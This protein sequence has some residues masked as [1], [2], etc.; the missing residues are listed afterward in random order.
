MAT[1]WNAGR[2]WNA[3]SLPGDW[4]YFVS[5]AAS[6]RSHLVEHGTIPQWNFQFCGGTPEL[7][8]PQ[9]WAYA[10]PS[11]FAY[12]LPPVIALLALWAAMTAL[13]AFSLWAWLR[14]S[15]Y[16]RPAA[17][18][19]VAT[20][21]FSGFF[22]AQFNQGHATFA[23]FHLIPPLLLTAD[24]F[25][26]A[27]ESA[28]ASAKA[29]AVFFVLTGLLLFSGGLPHALFYAYPALPLFLLVRSLSR[30]PK[31][32]ALAELAA[33][34]AASIGLAA[35]KLWPVI[36]WEMRHPRL[37]VQIETTPLTSILVS[38]GTAR[39][40]FFPREIFFPGQTWGS[41]EHDA[42]IGPAALLAAMIA[43]ALIFRRG[44]GRRAVTAQA[45]A[46]FAGVGL[47]L[48][49]GNGHPLSPAR[50][51]G[52]LP[53]LR[54][55]RVFARYQF[56]VV[57]GASI[58]T[59]HGLDFLLES[60]AVKRATRPAALL[61]WGLSALIAAPVLR[62]A[63]FLIRDIPILDDAEL[64]RSYELDPHDGT[65]KAAWQTA[66]AATEFLSHQSFLLRR[67]ASV[68]NCYEPL[69]GLIRDVPKDLLDRNA[70]GG[71]P[72]VPLSQPTTESVARFARSIA[73]R[74]GS[75]RRPD[76][77]VV[78]NYPPLRG[79]SISVPAD[80]TLSSPPQDP[81]DGD[82]KNKMIR[83]VVRFDRLPGETL[84][85]R[86]DRDWGAT[87]GAAVSAIALL[88][89]AAALRRRRVF[90]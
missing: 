27:R 2:S 87:A 42:Y 86:A 74:F 32:K 85:V 52:F 75:A 81:E 5:H 26:D 83:Q 22:A 14:R 71:P 89:A 64:D 13:G 61:A 84:R 56:L 59:A 78:L 58:L 24:S 39:R 68:I 40:S 49:L 48:A 38:L 46:A 90:G 50:F 16:S 41:W 88:L 72:W 4:D 18:A 35:Y 47:L 12:A 21:A 8:N 9:S 80:I 53:L 23:F 10:W 82:E 6:L 45:A 79:L 33:L 29:P 54:G 19:A 57:L 37:G 62:Q 43:T 65:P 17:A 70:A 7:A 76:A 63:A 73:I 36:L 15:G 20:Y 31:P 11:L 77:P 1:L 51:F 25:L 69:G 28:G 66:D 3:V 30:A 34:H 44:A 55:V 67:G 60:L